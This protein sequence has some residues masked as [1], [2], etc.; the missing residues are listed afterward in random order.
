MHY[1]SSINIYDENMK[2]RLL[3]NPKSNKT[4]RVACFMSGSGTNVR[5]IIEYQIKL[6]KERGK[7]PYEVVLIF[8]DNPESNAKKIAEEY[9]ISLEVNDIKNFYKGRDLKDTSIREEFDKKTIELIKPY[10]VDLI[11]LGGYA[12]LITKPL[13]S[14]YLIVNV[15]PADL[16]VNEKGKRKYVGLYHIPVMKAILNG[17]K[18]LHSSIHIVTEDVDMGEILVISKPLKVE[19]P[20]E[21]TVEDLKK[22]ENKELLKKISEEHQNKL[23]E[24][25]DWKIFPLSLQWIAEGRFGIDQKRNVYFDG[26]LIKIGYRLK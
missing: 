12:W 26:K 22:L 14:K 15:H 4:M 18:S 20:N 8:T 7:S 1:I 21:I 2:L 5:K 13:I 16:S 24:V 6:K 17:Q 9:G 23:K 19:L 10:N 25:G 11:A 3:F